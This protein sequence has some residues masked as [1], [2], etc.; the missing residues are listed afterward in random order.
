MGGPLKLWLM[1]AMI[2][3]DT[4]WSIVRLYRHGWIPLVLIAVP[5]DDRRPG[6]YALG[7]LNMS[8]DEVKG[9]VLKTAEAMEL[10]TQ[11]P[12][13]LEGHA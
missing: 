9:V 7:L 12:N 11:L 2:A 8:A 5:A 3:W 13:P 10:G 6:P 4:V 1:V